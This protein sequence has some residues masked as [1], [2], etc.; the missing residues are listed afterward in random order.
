MKIIGA[1]YGRTGTK[2]LQLA[3]EQLGFGKCYH[4]EELFRNPEGVVHWKD[5]M[6]GN[7]VAWDQ[8]FAGYQAIVDFPGA[9]YWQQ[10]SEYYPDAKVILTVR[11]P[12][13]WHESAMRTIYGFDPGPKMKLRLLGKS[14]VSSKARNL[15]RVLMLNDKSVWQTY[16]Q[17]RF[18]D[19]DYAVDRFRKHVE[20]VQTTLPSD[21]LL[22]YE[23]GQG[24]EPLCNFL[25]V[26]VPATPFPRTNL[27][28]DFSVWAKGIVDDVLRTA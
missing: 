2:S 17:D 4:M 19:R 9:M 20:E 7:P 1:G 13:K 12:E 15:L 16:F 11:D 6:S 5:A 18:A 25:G 21:R 22:V 3:L 10:L 28:D 27:R 8:L 26:P 14:V 23:A 24:W